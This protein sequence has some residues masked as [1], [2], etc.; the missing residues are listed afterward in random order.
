MLFNSIDFAIFLPIVFALFWFVTNRNLKLQNTMLLLAAYLFYGWWDWRFLFLL[1]FSS[2]FDYFVGLALSNQADDR[3]RKILFLSSITVNLTILGFFKYYNFFADSFINTFSFFGMSFKPGSLNVVLPVGISFY[4]FQS[5]SYAFDI[6]RRK[7]SPTK[8]II[9]FMAF[10]SFFPQL[11]AGPIQRAAHLLPQFFVKKQFNYDMVANGLK[12]MLLG[13]FMK[14]VVADRLSLYVDAIYGNV[15]LHTGWSYLVATFFFAIQIYGDFAGYSLIAIGCAQLFGFNLT[16]NF[17][18]PY[19]SASFREFWSR[20]HISLSTWFRDYLYIP[21]GGNR[22][23]KGRTYFNLFTTFVIS[24]LWHGANWTFVI[25]GAIHG[26]F[27]IIE[28]IFTELK[29]PKLPKFLSIILVFAVT[30]FAWVFF[31][32]A[33]VQDAFHIV[34]TVFSNP[35][36]TIH[37][38][39]K[40]IFAFSVFGIIILIAVEFMNEYYPEVNLLNHRFA[41]VRYATILIMLI[42][43]ISLGVFDGSQFIYFQF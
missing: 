29:F 21:L 40:G 1:I 23:S 7:L 27:Q 11:V 39:D 34:S 38:G 41:P 30:C 4:T 17:N 36:N 2:V 37:I 8:D 9:A 35:G 43:I 12:T 22:G 18:R 16:Q 14:V 33:N 10:V 6:Y 19:F 5:M 20:W 3:K 31:R 25:W 26:L 28:R 42:I 13:F 24:G 32:A 15:G